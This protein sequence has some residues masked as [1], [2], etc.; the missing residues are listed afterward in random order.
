MLSWRIIDIQNLH[1]FASQVL[2]WCCCCVVSVAVVVA[3]LAS[4]YCTFFPLISKKTFFWD[5]C[6]FPNKLQKT[7]FDN[8]IKYCTCSPIINF[9]MMWNVQWITKRKMSM[10][11]KKY[12]EKVRPKES[13]GITFYLRASTDMWWHQQEENGD[14]RYQGTAWLT[15][16]IMI[17]I[18]ALM[19][20]L[21]KRLVTTRTQTRTHAHAHIRTNTRTQT[22]TRTNTRTRTHKHGLY[23]TLLIIFFII[24][25][26]IRQKDQ[27]LSSISYYRK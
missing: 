2:N 21:I 13:Q 1:D 3:V 18:Y 16:L 8:T 19:K 10:N 23:F 11:C 27:R 7:T 9:F 20:I 22:H 4:Q 14:R 5:Q 17:L 24:L 6:F 15:E 26:C 12:I 25:H